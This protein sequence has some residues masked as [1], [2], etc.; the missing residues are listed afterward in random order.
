MSSTM[1]VYEYHDPNSIELYIVAL[2]ATVVI[3]FNLIDDKNICISCLAYII[4]G[5]QVLMMLNKSSYHFELIGDEIETRVKTQTILILIVLMNFIGF[6]QFVR[7]TGRI[8][9]GMMIPGTI[10]FVV[11]CITYQ[12]DRITSNII[13]S[14]V[15]KFIIGFSCFIISMIIGV[16]ICYYFSCYFNDIINKYA[17]KS[18]ERRQFEYYYKY[19]NGETPSYLYQINYEN[20][21][22]WDCNICKNSFGNTE[23]SILRCGHRFHNKC[24]RKNELKQFNFDA[25]LYPTYKCPICN[26]KYNYTQKWEYKP[27]NK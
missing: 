26:I 3:L 8:C 25:K 9:I 7:D 6:L 1:Y 11:V 12:Y 21:N 23:Q 19:K 15:I 24:L 4:G 14:M 18:F 22:I 13:Y 10:P 17:F 16:I 20:E 5:C 2:I 27:T